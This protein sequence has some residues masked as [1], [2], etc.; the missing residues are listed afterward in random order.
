[1]HRVSNI[2]NKFKSINIMEQILQV[3]NSVT[4]AFGAPIAAI[5]IIIIGWFVAKLIKKLVKGLFE[6]SGVDKALKSKVSIGEIIAKFVYFLVMIF[7]FMLAL[8]KLGMTSVLEP[9]K[10]LLNEFTGSIDN[11]VKAGIVGYVG[12]MLATI[13]SE[14]VGLSGDTIKSFAPKLHLPQNIDIVN[15]L[16][17]VVFIIIFIPLLIQALQFL[18]MSVITEPATAMLQSFMAAIPKVLLASII[19]I[20]AV[21]GGK[22]ITGLLKGLLEALNLNEVLGKAGLT[23]VLGG[24]NI[25]KLI[26]NVVYAFIILFGLMTALDKLEFTQLSEMMNTVVDLGGN[27]LFGLIILAI[28]NWIATVAAKNFDKNGQNPF[29]ASVIR[30][31]ILAVFLA[32]GLTKM[33]IAENIV[34]MAFGITLGTV[35]LTV[36]L[37]FGLGG[38]QAAGEQMKKILDKFNKK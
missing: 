1:M 2:Y 8:E 19:M 37:S 34:N 4:G 24:T 29:V 32:I 21:V 30:V 38:R 6:R 10:N 11:L 27:I 14:L 12:Y 13:V 28:G 9:V 17:K 20:I 22:F 35:A 7:V 36:V 23:S 33:G 18:N 16:K 15:V 26:C 31:A 5:I 3:F 25:V